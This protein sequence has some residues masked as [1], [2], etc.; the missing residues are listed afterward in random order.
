MGKI[1]QGILG[2]LSGKVGNVIGGSWKGINYIR[3]KPA[4]VANPRTQG[5]VNQRTKFSSVLEFLKPMGEFIKV[6]YKTTTIKQTAFNAAMSYNLKN[7]ITGTAPNFSV[8]YPNA[9]VSKGSLPGVVNGN[10]A[11]GAGSREVDVTWDDN[12][13]LSDASAFDL[14]L[15]L[16]YNPVKNQAVYTVAGPSRSDGSETL[17]L[18]ADF[19]GDTVYAYLGFI[20][21]DSTTVSNSS[22]LGS[23]T[24]A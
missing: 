6:G 8:D 10:A 23:L 15:I 16:I 18:P 19:I 17:T 2:G 11:A 22:Y 21:Q 3:I 12:S 14:S 20:S 5:Q 24:I 7:A 4:S 1:A 13:T 9:L